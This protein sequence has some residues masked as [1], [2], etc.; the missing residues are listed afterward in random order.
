MPAALLAVGA[1]LAVAVSE[2]GSELARLPLAFP[3]LSPPLVADFDGD[4]LNDLLFAT[5][6]GLFGYAQVQ[7]L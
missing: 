2:H 3:P 7:H 1:D 5:A 6:G 4:G